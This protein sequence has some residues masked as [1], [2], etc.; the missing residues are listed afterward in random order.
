MTSAK[1]IQMFSFGYCGWGNSTEQL[2]ESVDAVE[3]SRGFRPPIFADVRIRRQGRAVGFIGTAFEKLLGQKR[4]RWMPQ[5][6]NR[7]I[8][9]RT[10]PKLQIADPKAA[11]ELVELAREAHHDR[12]RVIFFCGCEFPKTDGIVSC[13][14][15]TVAKL[16]LKAA[17]SRGDNVEV[18]EWPGGKPRHIE[19]ETTPAIWRSVAKGQLSIPVGDQL[20]MAV[21]AGI[22][23]GS[24]A[25]L[26]AGYERLHRLVGPAKWKQGEWCLPVAWWY[27]YDPAV[28]LA[29]YKRYAEKSRRN[30]GMEPSRSKPKGK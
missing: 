13:H 17:A 7:R 5:L 28:T 20:P 27:W 22:P 26:R 24:T 12:R 8:V 3:R 11:V 19:I 15:H 4:H 23:W 9:T 1:P 25:T 29:A 14:R 6:G 10:G 30:F 2:I 18:V 21:I 16:L